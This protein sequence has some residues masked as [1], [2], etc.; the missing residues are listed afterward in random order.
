VSFDVSF[1]MPLPEIIEGFRRRPSSWIG[2]ARPSF[3]AL[4]GL[5]A[6]YAEA[7]SE[8]RGPQAESPLPRSLD[9]FIRRAINAKH[10]ETKY[11]AGQS[12]ISIITSEAADDGAAL[13]LFYELWDAYKHEP[14]S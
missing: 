4:A 12:W 1:A 2:P 7:Y 5:I 13:A 11:G 9:L 3:S 6:G 8:L 10:P 14:K